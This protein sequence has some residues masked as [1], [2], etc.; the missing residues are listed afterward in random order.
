MHKKAPIK[1]YPPLPS[2]PGGCWSSD[3]V[4]CQ[5]RGRRVGSSDARVGIISFGPGGAHPRHG[6]D[7]AAAEAAE[8][9]REDKVDDD[10]TLRPVPEERSAAPA[11]H[12]G[13]GGGAW[14]QS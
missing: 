11:H 4:G 8:E 6:A 3:G 1:P 10:P 7:G 9:P 12:E 2:Q 14:D 13:G 5:L